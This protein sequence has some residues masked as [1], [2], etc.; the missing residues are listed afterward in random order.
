MYI[1]SIRVDD[2][3]GARKY[4]LFGLCMQFW[5]HRFWFHMQVSVLVSSI[6]IHATLSTYWV[7]DNVSTCGT[8]TYKTLTGS[9]VCLA[10]PT[11]STTNGATAC[12]SYDQCSCLAGYARSTGAAGRWR[13]PASFRHCRL[14]LLS[15]HF[16]LCCCC[17]CCLLLLAMTT[18]MN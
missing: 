10:C 16:S 11:T 18:T 2:P 3:G 1:M 12:T 15:C 8:D 14:R 17:C 9:S 13:W 6:L 4:E 5:F 7:D